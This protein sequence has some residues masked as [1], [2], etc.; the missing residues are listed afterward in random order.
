MN[1]SQQVM[2]LQVHYTIH[3]LFPSIAALGLPF[4]RAI[5]CKVQNTTVHNS[6]MFLKCVE[7]NK[8]KNG[9][10]DRVKI[11]INQ[12]NMCGNEDDLQSTPVIH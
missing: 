6:S 10:N 9:V 2:C 11:N 4:F 7:Q 8:I 3:T 12:C 5:T 1:G